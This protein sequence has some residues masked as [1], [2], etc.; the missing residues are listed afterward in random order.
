MTGAFLADLWRSCDKQRQR[1]TY[2]RGHYYGTWVYSRNRGRATFVER[3]G[4]DDY[5]FMCADIQPQ[6]FSLDTRT[7]PGHTTSEHA[8]A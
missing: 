8:D 7:M 1:L 3:T 6:A 2:Y 4:T 5:L